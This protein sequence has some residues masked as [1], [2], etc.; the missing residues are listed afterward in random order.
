MKKTTSKKI[1][2][3]GA[4]SAALLG[5]AGA[6]GQVV[7]TDIDPDADLSTVGDTQ[8]IDFN[9]D[10]IV[11]ITI[12]LGDFTGG[13]AAVSRASSSNQFFGIIAGGFNY[14]SN[15]S[16][17]ATIDGSSLTN[18]GGR[19]DL[20]F[21]ACYPN[22]QWCGDT[23]DGF[24]GAAFDVGGNTHY[25]WVRMEVV[26]NGSGGAGSIAVRDFAFEATPDTAITAGDGLGVEDNAFGNFE[27]F[28]DNEQLNMRSALPM[29][30]VQIYNILGQ[31]VVNQRL[32]G[33]SES[34][35]ISAMSTGVYITRVTIDGQTKSF[36]IV[37]R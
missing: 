5:T 3:Y 23:G 35:N 9:D 30:N 18:A 13:A 2:N 25:G 12:E 21:Y 4:M 19:G 11:D 8:E 17:G 15:L 1:L 36:K 28:V 31:G 29:E 33:T 22:S 37:K 32:S 10:G 26:S 24:L 16:A 34:V 6:F 20:Y 27:F 7:Y 14:P